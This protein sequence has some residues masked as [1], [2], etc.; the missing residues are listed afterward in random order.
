MSRTTWVNL[1]NAPG[2]WWYAFAGS[3]QVY[4]CKVWRQPDGLQYGGELVANASKGCKPVKH[5][6]RWWWGFCPPPATPAP[7]DLPEVADA[8]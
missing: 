7:G 2:L 8:G 6:R 1:P 4:S 3:G 5:F